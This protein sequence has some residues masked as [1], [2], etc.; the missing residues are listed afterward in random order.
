[1]VNENPDPQPFSFF[2]CSDP[3]TSAVVE[4]IS[5]FLELIDFYVSS[6]HVE[7]L[8]CFDLFTK[9]EL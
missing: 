7:T 5:H 8:E 1:M 2:D 3:A 4:L 6:K 9:S